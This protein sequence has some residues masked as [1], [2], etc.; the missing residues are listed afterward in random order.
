MK[1]VLMFLILCTVVVSGQHNWSAFKIGFFSPQ[2]SDGGLI[3]GYQGGK[4]VDEYIDIGWS[5]DW[6]NKN[7]TDKSLANQFNE[8]NPG[9]SGEVNELR[10][11]T[12]LHDIP[13]MFNLT[14]YFDAGR[15][16]A[17]F[18]SVGVGAEIL[19]VF[20]RDYQNPDEDEL[21][22]A[23]DFSWRLSGGVI[24]ELGRRSELILEVGY[25]AS[26]P[27]W[28]FEV[29]DDLGRKRVFERKYDMSGMMMRAGVKIFY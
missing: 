6:F 26:E 22:G 4:Y 29:E 15:R 28:E 12:N 5:V 3:L 10:A 8:F 20:Y 11:K 16:L 23:F 25:H 24:Y 13:I 9:I 7:Y 14:G 1:K 21:K 17:A 27:S 18:A 2:A 19:L